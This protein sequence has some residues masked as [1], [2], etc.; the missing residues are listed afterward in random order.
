MMIDLEPLLTLLQ[1][2]RRRIILE[3]LYDL[4]REQDSDEV[5]VQV[6][7]LVRQVA[8]IEANVDSTTFERT[9]HRSSHIELHHTHLPMLDDY[10]VIE[11]DTTSD[12][13]STTDHTQPIVQLLYRI[14]ESV[15]GAEIERSHS[16]SPE[17]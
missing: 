3:L 10:D 16:T 11:Y 17:R 6:Q 12:E 13:V 15:E 5:T 4:Q 8:A 14:Q 1:S 2:K 9:A 7:D